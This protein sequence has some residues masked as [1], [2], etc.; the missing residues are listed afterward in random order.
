M[1]LDLKSLVA[2]KIAIL[3]DYFLLENTDDTAEIYS[4]GCLP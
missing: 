2:K 1:Q 4:Q 3:F